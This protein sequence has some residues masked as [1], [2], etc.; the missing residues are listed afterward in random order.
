MQSWLTLVQFQGSMHVLNDPRDSTTSHVFLGF[1]LQIPNEPVHYFL[2]QTGQSRR[3]EERELIQFVVFVVDDSIALHLRM[4]LEPRKHLVATGLPWH[5]G[6]DVD[7]RNAPMLGTEESGRIISPRR[8]QDNFRPAPLKKA[9]KALQQLWIN[10]I[11]KFPRI[12]RFLA[13]KNTIDVQKNDLHLPVSAIFA[14]LA[15]LL[16]GVLVSAENE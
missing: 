14:R 13:I 15:L 1:S 16:T 11:G 8:G 9:Q 10:N 4:P 2:R 7:K 3:L 6:G 12:G 5:V